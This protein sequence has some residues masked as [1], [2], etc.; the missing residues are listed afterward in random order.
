MKQG[1]LRKESSLEKLREWIKP[2]DRVYTIVRHRS[3][4]N[5]SRELGV[6]I[7]REGSPLHPNYAVAEVLGLRVNKDG[8]G[9][10]GQRGR[11]GY[12]VLVGL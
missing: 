3:R 1:E 7:F 4:S 10:K 9:V 12:G 5:M 11:D 8:D 2:G 6:V